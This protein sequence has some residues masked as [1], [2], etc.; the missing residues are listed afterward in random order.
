MAVDYRFTGTNIDAVLITD[1]P[2]GAKT[3][4][5]TELRGHDSADIMAGIDLNVQEYHEADFM[6]MAMNNALDLFRID[7][8]GEFCLVMQGVSAGRF[9]GSTSNLQIADVTLA[10]SGTVSLPWTFKA[11]VRFT[12]GD[13]EN[14]ASFGEFGYSIFGTPLTNASYV[15]MSI[16]GDTT[17]Q[18]LVFVLETS[19]GSI[20]QIVPYNVPL[21]MCIEIEVRILSTDAGP[22][23]QLLINGNQ[24]D[25]LVFA[26]IL[27]LDQDD[28]LFA[29]GAALFLTNPMPTFKGIMR[30]LVVS[31]SSGD[32]INIV[33]PSTGTNTGS[34]ADGTVTDIE[35]VTVII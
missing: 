17:S 12:T 20:Q 22:M 26:E 4:F 34:E 7:D 23:Y 3:F 18:V 10:S 14:L 16:A 27:T 11:T 8:T 28:F 19:I 15:Y 9:N 6:Q 31:D 24:V 30:N 2:T 1:A 13:L 35:S 33:D 32:L 21:D 5:V 29:Y 25:S